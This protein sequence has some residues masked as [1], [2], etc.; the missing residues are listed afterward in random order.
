LN[1]GKKK[2]A[3]YTVKFYGTISVSKAFTVEA[4]NQEAAAEMVDDLGGQEILEYIPNSQ[5]GWEANVD[6]E[7][8]D[9]FLLTDFL[10]IEDEEPS[11]SAAN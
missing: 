6:T 9:D 11:E 4:E 3:K 1:G 5:T 2:M 7:V 10:W 8:E